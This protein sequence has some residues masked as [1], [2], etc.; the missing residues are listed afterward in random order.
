MLT[1]LLLVSFT[2]WLVLVPT[3]I[4]E[5]LPPE[6]RSYLGHG[7][8]DGADAAQMLVLFIALPIAFG[9]AGYLSL[10]TWIVASKPFS[11]RAEVEAYLQKSLLGGSIGRLESAVLD[12]VFGKSKLL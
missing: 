6:V 1:I 4:W 11:T 9:I 8:T 3:T 12:A 5:F 10:I 2:F 7:H